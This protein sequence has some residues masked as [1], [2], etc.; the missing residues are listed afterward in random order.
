MVY[1]DKSVAQFMIPNI[2]TFFK[3]VESE[4]I[5]IKLRTYHISPLFNILKLYYGR[6]M[7]LGENLKLINHLI[8]FK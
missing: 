5:K 3:T 1:L 2:K 7:L 4:V 8:N 6:I